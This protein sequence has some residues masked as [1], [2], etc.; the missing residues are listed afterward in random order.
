MGRTKQTVE[1]VWRRN[2]A[3]ELY[4]NMKGGNG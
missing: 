1:N 4:P 2:K 3:M